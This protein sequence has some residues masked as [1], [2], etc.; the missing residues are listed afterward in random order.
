MVFVHLLAKSGV[1]GTAEW[2]NV[3][4][5]DDGARAVMVLLRCYGLSS[6]YGIRIN[7]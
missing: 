1:Y 6:T 4:K 2:S 5:T 7:H 3:A